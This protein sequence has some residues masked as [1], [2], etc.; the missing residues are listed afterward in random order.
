MV[1][2]ELREADRCYGIISHHPGGKDLIGILECACVKFPTS[3][4]NVEPLH[5]SI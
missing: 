1:T 5:L 2:F 4:S 3:G